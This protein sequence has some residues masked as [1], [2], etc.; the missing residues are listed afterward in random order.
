MY[1]IHNI[2]RLYKISRKKKKIGNATDSH[3][4]LKNYIWWIGLIVMVLGE[5]MNFIGKL[6]CIHYC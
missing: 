3:R 5:V 1:N 6:M 2:R 4:Y